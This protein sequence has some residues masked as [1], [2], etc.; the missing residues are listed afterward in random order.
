MYF[1]MVTINDHKSS[2]IKA[3]NIF[4]MKTKTIQK[5]C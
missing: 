2:S 5:M 4:E 3:R 1:H